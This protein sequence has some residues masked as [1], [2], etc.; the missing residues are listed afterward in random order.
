MYV[1]APD[2]LADLCGLSLGLIVLV[3]PVGLLLWL[4]G[5]WS[6]R[7]WI[8]LTTTVLAGVFGLI[9]ATAWKV[10][11]ILVAVLLAIAAGVLALALIRVITFAAGGFVGSYL[12]Q[13]LA[14]SLNQP[15]ICF[16]LSGLLCLLLFRW[17]FMV[18]T[19]LL[20]SSL[21]VYG[22]LALLHYRETM[23]AL[24]WSEQNT[25]TLNILCSSLTLVGLAFQFVFD[26]WRT[27]RRKERAEA[28]GDDLL[29]SVLGKIGGKKKVRKVA[30]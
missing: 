1:I 23:D 7:F 18:L 3:L 16:L 30:A 6:H 4:L 24:A 11:P 12:V 2:I 27:R 10:Q 13:V 9:E 25:L 19:S 21:L 15:I 26:R 14:P 29:S 17:F 20:G 8:V 22:T 28:G 5:W